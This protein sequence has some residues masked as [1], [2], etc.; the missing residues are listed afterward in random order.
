MHFKPRY[1]TF[2]LIGWGGIFA[3]TL[4]FAHSMGQLDEVRWIRILFSL[5][6]GV[7]LS[8]LMRMLVRRSRLLDEPFLR[9]GLGFL[10]ITVLFACLAS[11]VETSFVY[12]SG[13][14][15]SLEKHVDFALLNL[16]LAIN[17]FIVFFLWNTCYFLYHYVSKY[18]RHEMDTLR[19]AS[20]V[21]ELELKSIKSYINPHFIFNALNSIRALVD[22]DPT[23]A[24]NAV[25]A[26]GNILRSSLQTEQQ[27]TVTLQKELSIVKD[28]LALQHIRFEDRLAVEYDIDPSTLNLPVPIM[29]L[30]MLVENAVKH[31]ISR[32]VSGGLV[33]IVS[34]RLGDR[35]E[36]VV[37]NSGHLN[38]NLRHSGFGWNSTVNRLQL[39]FGDSA[40]FKITE[41]PERMVEAVVVM[42][43]MQSGLSMNTASVV[44]RR[45][46]A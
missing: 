38:R 42:P 2:Q 12:F 1:W 25:T 32:R 9:Q 44:L 6:L 33:R 14:R 13:F 29:M 19:L 22:E 43:V 40:S 20:T 37:K 34:R 21:K 27:E 4:F 18:R 5:S 3:A 35:F 36:L 23:R 41:T 16:S 8:H 46:A 39:L 24:R 15:N 26:L 11:M 31:G 28:Y 45:G 10:F 30:Q 7:T 17:A